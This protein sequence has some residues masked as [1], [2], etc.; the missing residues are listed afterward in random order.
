MKATFTIEVS[1]EFMDERAAQFNADVEEHE[2]STAAEYF[3]GRVREIADDEL[4]LAFFG[5]PVEV[6]VEVEA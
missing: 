6:T 2:G 5:W 3:A 1:D 4:P